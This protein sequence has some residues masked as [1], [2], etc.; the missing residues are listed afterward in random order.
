MEPYGNGKIEII[1]QTKQLCC[2]KKMVWKMNIV[3]CDSKKENTQ[4]IADKIRE[5]CEQDTV[6]CVNSIF[7]LVTYLYD[8]AKGNVDALFL[9]VRVGQNNGIKAAKEIQ[10]FY[11]HIAI[12]FLS[13]DL[14]AVKDIFL[15]RP[16]YFIG[17]PIEE[18]YL[19]RA[20]ERLHEIYN[21]EVNTSLT[22]RFKNNTFRLNFASVCYIE[23]QGRKIIIYALNNQW[24]VNM[25]M[26][27]IMEKLPDNFKMCH[28]SYIVNVQKIKQIMNGELELI[29]QQRIPFSRRR[30]AEIEL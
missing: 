17:I 22:L 7:E 26:S 14:C 3:I 12:I 28:R 30:M 23:S 27:E 4:I 25:T 6:K 9:N 2:V 11:P 24:E 19:R 20:W 29:N 18:M 15:I 16:V 10:D 8:E 13:E 1:M 21:E 5:Y